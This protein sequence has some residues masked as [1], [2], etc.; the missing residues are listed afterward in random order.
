ME[1]LKGWLL[2]PKE[3]CTLEFTFQYGEIK[4]D[5]EG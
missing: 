3:N 4:S 2:A 1:R 5:S